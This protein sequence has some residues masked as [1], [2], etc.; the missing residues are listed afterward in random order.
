VKQRREWPVVVGTTDG[1]LDVRVRPG[2]SGFCV[3]EVLSNGEQVV[4]LVLDAI[5]VQA[6]FRAAREA[7]LTFDPDEVP[8]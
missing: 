4:A 6:L 7:V 8:F 2:A 1:G 5:D 3:F